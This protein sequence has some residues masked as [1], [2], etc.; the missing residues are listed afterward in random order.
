MA[1]EIDVGTQLVDVVTAVAKMAQDVLAMRARISLLEKANSDLMDDWTSTTRR[2]H[3]VQAELLALRE[4]EHDHV[5][6]EDGGS[7]VDAQEHPG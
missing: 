5:R 3:N 7:P 6:D 4:A 1:T 2:L